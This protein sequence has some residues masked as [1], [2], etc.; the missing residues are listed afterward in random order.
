MRRDISCWMHG[1]LVCATQCVGKAVRHPLTPIPVGGPFDRVGVDIIQ[2]PRSR[3]GNQYA[4][5]FVDYLTKWHTIAA[6]LSQTV[7][8]ERI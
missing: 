3:Q 4:V 5:V 6:K 8:F 7:T 1:C 2:L